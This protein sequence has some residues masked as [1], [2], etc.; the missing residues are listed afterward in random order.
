[1]KRITLGEIALAFLWSVAIMAATAIPYGMAHRGAGAER[2][3][4][5]FIWGVDDG[6]V[7]LSW[8]RQASEGRV[9]LRN[10][11]TT[12]NQSPH[13]FSV[14]LLALGRICAWTGLSPLAA[15]MGSRYVCGVFCL[16]AFYAL[17]AELTRSRVARFAALGLASV[18]SGLGWIVVLVGQGGQVLPGLSAFPMDVADGWQAQPEAILFSSLLLNPL[19]AFSLGLVSLIMLHASRLTSRAGHAQCSSPEQCGPASAADDAASGGPS[20]LHA[21]RLTSR[22]GYA[23]AFW[24]GALLLLLG[25]VHGYDIFP[26]HATLILWLGCA[27]LAGR[28]T[29]GRAVGQYALIVAISVASPLWAYCGARADPSYAAKVSTP[30]LSPRPFDVA[31]GYGLVLALALWGAWLVSNAGAEAA[32]RRN[33]LMLGLVA[34]VGCAGLVAQQAGAPARLL[35]IAAFLLPVLAVAVL[36][37]RREADEEQWRALLP[38]LWATCAAAMI[39]LPVSFQRKMMEGL[40]IP[41]CVLGG[42]ALAA[43]VGGRGATP[44]GGVGYP[45]R[46][47][48][49]LAIL[50][51]T[52][53]SNVVFVG[54]CMRHVQANNRMLLGVLAPPVYLSNAEV[55]AMRW[56]GRNTSERDVALASSLTGNYIPAHAPCLVVAGHWAETLNFGDYLGLVARFYDPASSREA[57]EAALARSGAACVWWGPQERL[58]QQAMGGGPRDPCRELT[59]LELVHQNS[60]VRIYQRVRASHDE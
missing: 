2:E 59:G 13:F 28:L 18:S 32:R 15:F 50:L 47:A 21:S 17:V 58:L 54:E 36:A 26:L 49:A 24:V 55:E 11:Y 31:I 4:G 6:N 44:R 60:A 16:L 35:G 9:L 45:V 52:V 48:L 3:F 27:W 40:H 53:P 33:R 51:A 20:G 38:V 8:V 23:A 12:K 37:G 56:L 46:I 10:Q 1:M 39:Y 42:F 29:L 34:I 30:T 22:G 41:L 7:Y 43:F 57:R 19:F 25:N 14:F 5:G